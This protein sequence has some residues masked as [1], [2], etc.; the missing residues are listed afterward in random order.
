MDSCKS[1][2]HIAKD[3]IHTDTTT[4]NH[5]RSTALERSVVDNWELKHVLLDPNLALCFRNGS[6]QQK[7]L[8]P[9]KQTNEKIS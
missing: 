6:T 5:T 7:Q 9:I 8:Q 4:C 1:E 3:H 2:D